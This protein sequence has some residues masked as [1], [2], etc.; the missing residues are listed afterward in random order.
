MKRLLLNLFIVLPYFSLLYGGK[1]KNSPLIKAIRKKNKEKVSMLIKRG[2][3][4]NIEGKRQDVPLLEASCYNQLDVVKEL[5]DAGCD[6][7]IQSKSDRWTALMEASVRGYLRIVVEL[8]K[9]G[10]EV[11]RSNQNGRTALSL[12]AEKGKIEVVKALIKT[13]AN[14]NLK[15][16]QSLTALY[17]ALKNNHDDLAKELIYAKAYVDTQDSSGCT[18]LMVFAYKNDVEIL[19]YLVKN[20]ASLDIQNQQGCT[21]LLVATCY[22]RKEALKYLIKAGANID[23]QTKDQKA[24][25]LIY[26]IMNDYDEIAQ[27]LLEAFPNL[28]IQDKKGFTALMYSLI[29][30]NI[31][32]FKK[33]LCQGASINI[34]T[35][36]KQTVIDFSG[37]RIKNILI[38]IN[39][40]Y[41]NLEHNRLNLAQYNEFDKNMILAS[42]CHAL[43]SKKSSKFFHNVT[44]DESNEIGIVL[45]VLKKWYEG[46]LDTQGFYEILYNKN[47]VSL[48]DLHNDLACPK[49]LKNIYRNKR[50]TR[51]YFKKKYTSYSTL[52]GKAF[53][54]L[55]NT[56]FDLLKKNLQRWAFFTRQLA[57][58]ELNNQNI[59]ILPE[60]ASKISTYI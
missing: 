20:N 5:L 36:K 54:I 22:Q 11:N 4:L 7:N 32:M 42:I 30:N 13:G 43:H 55:S 46:F 8:I 50:K 53:Y 17:Y 19:D 25:A 41:K 2:D 45:S 14:V 9:R 52:E 29:Y 28:D 24:T 35:K 44:Y 33:I 18:P 40:F 16:K 15:D 3:R 57:D 27:I 38:F 10:A 58:K 26:A 48:N 60:I 39:N 31:T 21:A 6:I 37:G 56:S 12:A 1:H 23:I 47:Y 51:K 59:I 49:I 34:K